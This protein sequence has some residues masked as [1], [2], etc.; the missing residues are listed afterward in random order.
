MAFQ[1]LSAHVT[2]LK[3]LPTQLA[4]CLM[5]IWTCLYPRW[6]WLIL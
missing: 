3:S 6:K 4:A 5:M 1:C 2:Q